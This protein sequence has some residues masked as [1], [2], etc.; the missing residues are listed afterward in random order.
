MAHFE[1]QLPPCVRSDLKEIIARAIQ[2][3]V[4]DELAK[5]EAE[6]TRI[7]DAAGARSNKAE[8]RNE[9]AIEL[10]SAWVRTFQRR[11]M[12]FLPKTP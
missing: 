6:A 1:Q 8:M 5:L 2:R 4:H 10:Q 3:A 12:E 9:A 7:A 11:K